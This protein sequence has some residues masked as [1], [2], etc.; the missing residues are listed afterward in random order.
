MYK[1]SDVVYKLANGTVV[2]SLREA[3]ESGL[4]FEKAYRIVE[5]EFLI[6]EIRATHRIKLV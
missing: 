3:K 4:A 6:G 2:E 1:M 5:E